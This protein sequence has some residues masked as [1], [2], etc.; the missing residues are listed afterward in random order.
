VGPR[1]LRH[2]CPEKFRAVCSRHSERECSRASGVQT[3]LQGRKRCYELAPFSLIR[4]PT[5]PHLPHPAPEIM[6]IAKRSPLNAGYRNIYSKKI[7]QISCQLVP[8]VGN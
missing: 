2:S 5:L 4:G 6:T 1:H 8:F 7:H 3:P